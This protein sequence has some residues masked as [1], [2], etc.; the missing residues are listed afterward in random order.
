MKYE[1]AHEVHET[2]YFNRK[3]LQRK[4]SEMSWASSRAG[5]TL[6]MSS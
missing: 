6:G 2:C 3:G 4:M 1:Q 5:H